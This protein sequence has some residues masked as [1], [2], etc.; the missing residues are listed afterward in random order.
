MISTNDL[1]DVNLSHKRWRCLYEYRIFTMYIASVVFYEYTAMG[2]EA[3][4]VCF[5]RIEGST[6]FDDL[7]V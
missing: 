6:L 5:D 2:A 3:V 1:I 4:D 7:S